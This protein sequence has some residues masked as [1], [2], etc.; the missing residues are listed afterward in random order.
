[1]N[2]NALSKNLF[3]PL[4]CQQALAISSFVIGLESSR[5][6][7]KAARSIWSRDAALIGE[8]IRS[9]RRFVHAS[10]FS[11]VKAPIGTEAVS[12][13]A[14]Y[15]LRNWLGYFDIHLKLSS[16]QLASVLMSEVELVE[17]I[18]SHDDNKVVGDGVRVAGSV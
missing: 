18:L 10:L 11:V 3:L 5:Q 15:I 12:P 8:E 7:A 2:C 13:A 4:P 16:A 14:E 9:L 1:M 6:T 17:I